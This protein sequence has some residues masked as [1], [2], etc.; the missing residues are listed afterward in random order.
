MDSW[1]LRIHGLMDATDSWMLRTHGCYGLMDVMDS[2]NQD[3]I[4]PR[5]RRGPWIDESMS[6]MDYGSMY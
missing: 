1:M 2:I 6:S 4:M 5:R 3:I